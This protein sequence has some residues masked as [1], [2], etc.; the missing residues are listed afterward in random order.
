MTPRDEMFIWIS[1]HPLL[2]HALKFLLQKVVHGIVGIYM[3]LRI[4]ADLHEGKY[5]DE[6]GPSD[7][8]FLIYST[9]V[10]CV[11][12]LPLFITAWCFDLIPIGTTTF[13]LASVTI[14]FLPP[15]LVLSYCELSLLEAKRKNST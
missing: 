9:L 8:I 13:V 12:L 15:A 2:D 3:G 10:I 11:F 4:T 14:F 7:A 5:A 1:R 6:L